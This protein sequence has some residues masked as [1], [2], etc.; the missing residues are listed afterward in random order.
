MFTWLSL[1]LNC[2]PTKHNAADLAG[3]AE[4]NEGHFKG[5]VPMEEHAVK[6]VCKRICSL[7]DLV[8]FVKNEHGYCHVN[9]RLINHNKPL[10]VSLGLI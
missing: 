1:R 5:G 9:P 2:F 8:V 6:E 3:R 4:G 7:S 10:P